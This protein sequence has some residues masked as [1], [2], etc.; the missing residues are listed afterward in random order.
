MLDND[1]L[2]QKLVYEGV[3]EDCVCSRST[4][5]GIYSS[6]KHIQMKEKIPD[7]QGTRCST[8]ATLGRSAV[9]ETEY[10]FAA[11]ACRAFKDLNP[12]EQS[13]VSP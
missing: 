5:A 12:L 4:E 3:V 2:L 11:V 10:G 1:D 7:L 13:L 8:P 6:F 9:V